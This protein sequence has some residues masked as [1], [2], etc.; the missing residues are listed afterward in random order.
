MADQVQD[1]DRFDKERKQHQ[2]QGDAE[3]KRDYC[4]D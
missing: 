3:I 1:R 4:N 2:E